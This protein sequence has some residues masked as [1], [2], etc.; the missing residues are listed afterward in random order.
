MKYYKVLFLVILTGCM[1]PK[2]IV[3]YDETINFEKFKSY[4]FYEDNGDNLSVFDKKRVTNALESQLEKMGFH[5]EDTPDFYIYFEGNTSEKAFTNTI[6]IGLGAGGMNNGIGVSGGM[7][8]HAKKVNEEI[9]IQF[10]NAVTNELFWE[11]A[12]T[13]SIREK[14][15]PK[16]RAVYFTDVVA[17]ILQ[18]Y[19]PKN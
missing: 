1:V 2:V 16:K 17:K 9:S 4:N 19:P 12:L 7:P 14:R 3:D 10:V 15:N 5:L 18:Q 6:G 13:S 11:G 8:L